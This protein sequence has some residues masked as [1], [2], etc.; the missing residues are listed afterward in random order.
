MARTDYECHRAYVDVFS[1]TEDSPGAFVCCNRSLSVQSNLCIPPVRVT[2]SSLMA[3]DHCL[4]HL[5]STFILCN[6]DPPLPSPEQPG[7]LPFARRLAK[8]PDAWLIP[9][10]PLFVRGAVNVLRILQGRASNA[11]STQ[12]VRA[13]R[14]LYLY[15]GIIQ[16]RGWV[17]YLMF[18][19]LEE[20]I[21]AAAGTQCWYKRMLPPNEATCQGAVTDFSDHVV[22]Y[23]AQLLPIALTEVLHS[24]VMPFWT[25][26]DAPWKTG[27]T[28]IPT[29]LMMGIVYLYIITFLGAYKTAAYF[30][31]SP[32]V[33][34]GYVISLFIQ[35]PLFF[36]Q[37]TFIWPQ[38]REYF[39]GHTTGALLD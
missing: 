29:A 10:F 9:L 30:H 1:P 13:M 12:T 4:R 32:E 15:V 7:Y 14:R 36:L 16:V 31:T 20:W 5:T 11:S 33:F 6:D 38:A 37:C 27:N 3:D 21:V 17:L 18:N 26:S 35:V 19:E 39:F 8:F 25:A 22:L 28:V 23:F 2:R 24:F 34:S